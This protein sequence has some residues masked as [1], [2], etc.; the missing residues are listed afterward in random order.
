MH[1]T[2]TE[3]FEKTAFIVG[4]AKLGLKAIKPVVNFAKKKPL[5]AAFGGMFAADTAGQALKKSRQMHGKAIVNLPRHQNINTGMGQ[6][7]MR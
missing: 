4:A 7:T 5:T 2:F 6:A 3:S 1:P